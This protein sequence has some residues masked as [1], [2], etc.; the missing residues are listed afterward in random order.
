MITT[1]T[2]SCLALGRPLA[3]LAELLAP[4]RR[5]TLFVFAL[6]LLVRLLYAAAAARVD[7]FLA[8]NPLLGD[9]GSYNLIA[10]NVLAGGPYGETAGRA[11]AFWPPLYPL[12]LVGIYG[13]V[14]H[15]LL[16][17]RLAQAALGALLPPLFFLAVDRLGWRSAGRWASLG[18]ALYPLLIYFGA[19]LIAEA[20]FFA[21]S[22]LIFFAAAL[23]QRR[24]SAGAAALLGAALGLAALAKPTVLFQL[25]FLT[26][27]FLVSLETSPLWRRLAL[28][29]LAAAVMVATIAPWSVRN[30]LL[31]GHIVPIS[32]NGG[33]TFY[34]ANNADAFG[35]HYEHFPPRDFTLNEAEEQREFYRLGAQWIREYP[36][37]FAWLTWQKLRRLA[38]PLSV[39]SSPQDFRLPGAGLV[40]LAYS[41]FLGAALLGA[42]AS[43]RSWRRLFLLYVPVLGVLLSTLLFY[44]DARYTLPAVPSLLLFAVIGA[45]AVAARLGRR[46]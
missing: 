45:Q 25:P 28:G 20:L 10:R 22:G 14:G 6:A 30:Y 40:Y 38:S 16:A 17:A 23:L 46:M 41:L 4:P 2:A 3:S 19:W 24:P 9:A 33:Y 7:P 42:V 12:L 27:W 44:G 5:W 8:Q 34:G 13:S 32:T 26:L 1:K 21:L 15:N 31:L 11:S 36:R 43:R 39:A 18:V 37:D 35:G 29:V